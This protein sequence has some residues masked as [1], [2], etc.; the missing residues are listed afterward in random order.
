MP[1]AHKG[2]RVLD[3]KLR[4]ATE[5]ELYMTGAGLALGYAG[6][7]G[8]TADRFLPDPAGPPGARMYRTGDVGRWRPDG[9]LDVTGRTDDQVKIRGFRV[10]PGEVAAA[11]ARCPGVRDAAVLA[12][13][14]VPGE[15]RLAAYLT[16]AGDPPGYADVHA[17][18]AALLPDYM[19]PASLT[20]LD[21]LPLTANGKL[22]RAALPV[23][24]AAGPVGPAERAGTDAEQLVAGVWSEVLGVA[25][26]G[27]HDNFF[28]LGGNS[29]A[30]VRVALR[31][32]AETG[33]RVPPRLV[34]AAKTVSDLARRLPAS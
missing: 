8:L 2:V 20:V 31:L 9:T 27:R 3:R 30:A 4:P 18:L 15:H 1:V 12:H 16:A 6:R 22:D 10:E 24:A 33:T 19:I 28:R 26:V 21:A 5:G 32:S 17:H 13:E 23:P 25:A 7:P 11:L 34:F 29:L 14:P